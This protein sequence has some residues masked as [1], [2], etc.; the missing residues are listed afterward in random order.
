MDERPINFL[1]KKSEITA[2]KSIHIIHEQLVNELET[3]RVVV[4]RLLK[5]MKEEGLLQPGSNKIILM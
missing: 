2:P 5:Q 1:K 3:A 4:S